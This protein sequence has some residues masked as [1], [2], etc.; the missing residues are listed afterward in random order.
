[1]DFKLVQ[2]TEEDLM[3]YKADMQEA[4]QKVMQR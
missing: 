3:Q 2:I 4:F 1:M